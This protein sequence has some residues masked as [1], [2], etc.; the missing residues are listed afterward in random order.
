MKKKKS[1]EYRN[2]IIN[3]QTNKKTH[4]KV[5]MERESQEERRG[6][7]RERERVKIKK[8]FVTAILV[9]Y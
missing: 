8:L 1:F 5:K 4:I 9:Y 7:R 3:E 6:R 2:Q